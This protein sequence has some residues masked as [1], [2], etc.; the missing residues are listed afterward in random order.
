[1]DGATFKRAR[2]TIRSIMATATRRGERAVVRGRF[3]V[4]GVVMLAP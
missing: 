2:G 4:A 3:K 1:M